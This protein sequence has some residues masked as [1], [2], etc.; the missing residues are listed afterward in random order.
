M[1]KAPTL[2][3][4]AG[5][6]GGHI[7]PGLAVAQKLQ[8][9]GW[10]IHWLGSEN[11]MEVDLIPKYNIPM[12]L[13]SVSGIR[14][15]GIVRKLFSPLIICAAI[16]QARKVI[17]NVQPNVVMGMGG[18]ASGP[19]G[20]AAWLSRL[21][22]VIHEQNAVAGYTNRLLSKIATVVASAFEGAFK[23]TEKVKIVGNPVREM[24]CSLDKPQNRLNER[25]GALRILVVGGSRGAQILNETVPK[26]LAYIDKTMHIRHQT[27]RGNELHV[28]KLYIQAQSCGHQVT[29]SDF[30]EDMSQAF[31]WADL[32]ICRAGALTVSELMTVGLGALFVPYPHAVDDH[33]TFNALIMKNKGAAEIIQQSD[34]TAEGMADWLKQLNHKKI[35]NMAM[36]ALDENQRNATNTMVQLC[37]QL[38]APQREQK[39]EADQS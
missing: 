24:I 13:L 34:L 3:V 17:K 29:V 14:G 27:G 9:K 30:I 39:Q 26:A 38:C 28:E 8:Q 37:E 33:Q 5:G 16:I 36:N 12:T 6:T 11:G 32:V 1:N 22:L 31:S 10:N 19:G 15:K 35:T 25:A 23:K 21:P 20:V 7:F 2:M 4:M 18:F